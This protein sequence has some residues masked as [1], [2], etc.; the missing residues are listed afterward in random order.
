MKF[1]CFLTLLLLPITLVIWVERERR[2]RAAM[3]PEERKARELE[4]QHGPIDETITCIYCKHN[5]CVRTR[6]DIEEALFESL[7]NAQINPISMTKNSARY[8]A[9]KKD[10]LKAYC[11][12]CGAYWDMYDPHQKD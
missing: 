2:R 10:L 11:D 1:G 8:I 6:L 3:S 9:N 5:N 4:D 12:H 7:A